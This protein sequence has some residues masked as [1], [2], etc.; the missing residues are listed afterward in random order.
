MRR[1]SNGPVHVGRRR[2]HDVPRTVQILRAE[3]SANDF[4][5]RAG[6]RLDNLGRNHGH[7]RLGVDERAK[8]AGGDG[9]ATDDHHASARKLE[10]H[11]KDSHKNALKKRKPGRPFGLPG[12]GFLLLIVSTLSASFTEQD[13]GRD[14]HPG[15]RAT[16]DA[17]QAHAHVGRLPSAAGFCQVPEG[18]SPLLR[19][20]TL[21]Q[22]GDCP[23]SIVPY[24]VVVEDA[25]KAS[26][27][28]FLRTSGVS[29]TS[30]PRLD[31]VP[32]SDCG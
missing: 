31:A 12:F 7:R 32:P 21:P 27:S 26:S 3:R 30:I 2:G 9:S 5:R 23:V 4:D 19:K 25:R 6:N 11:W 17:G 28:T 1:G 18:D 15:C 22:K 8:L 14:G 13:L 24:G 20:R 16:T 29:A 10:K